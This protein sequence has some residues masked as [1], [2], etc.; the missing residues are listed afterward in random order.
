MVAIAGADDTL[1]PE[2][3][4]A[5]VIWRVEAS[6][7]TLVKANTAARDLEDEAARERPT[8]PILTGVSDV[9]EKLR[10]DSLERLRR[11]TGAER[12]AEALML[13]QRAIAAYAAAHALEPDA[14]R[15]E[16]ERAGQAGRR[17]S[18]VMN[19]LVG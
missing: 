10:A 17:P 2:M 5:G 1:P 19:D 4:L 7:L 8:G 16:L 9:G 6:G 13:G 18:R 14:A 3:A 12:F 11:M 15:R